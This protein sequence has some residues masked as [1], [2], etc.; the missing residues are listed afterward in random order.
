MAIKATQGTYGS[1]SPLLALLRDKLALRRRI[2]SATASRSTL[3][4]ARLASL[5]V[6]SQPDRVRRNVTRSVRF[7][8]DIN[9][10]G[11]VDID[12][13]LEGS[14]T[15]PANNVTVRSG[16]CVQGGV[17]ARNVVV[18]GEVQGDITAT[19]RIELKASARV[20]GDVRARR[21]SVRDGARIN[22]RVETA[23]ADLCAETLAD[24]L[25]S[26]SERQA[27]AQDS[28]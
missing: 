6:R 1:R 7:E 26:D 13:M 4:P 5:V 28:G 16:G 25:A 12:G 23:E 18:G 10:D 19:K 3:D 14:V 8:G 27:N 17:K 21:I 2:E 24:G 22:G 9:G 15:V 11:D 20:D